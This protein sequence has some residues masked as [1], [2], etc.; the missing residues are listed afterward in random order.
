MNRVMSRVYALTIKVHMVST[1]KEG[2]LF[3]G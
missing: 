1:E 2:S 3:Q